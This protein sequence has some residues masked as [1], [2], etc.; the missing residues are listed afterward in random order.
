MEHVYTLHQS[1]AGRE[2]IGRSTLNVHENLAGKD[3]SVTW[4]GMPMPTGLP[5]RWNFQSNQEALG[6][7]Q[8]EQITGCEE[9][10]A[11]QR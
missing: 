10:N 6:L 8:E 7:H 4:N 9:Q 1:L 3:V 5:T 11:D 2:M